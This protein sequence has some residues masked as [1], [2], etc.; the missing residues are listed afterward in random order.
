MPHMPHLTITLA[1]TGVNPMLVYLVLIFVTAAIVSLVFHRLRLAPIPA[2]LVAGAIIGP[3]IL[4]IITSDQEIASISHLAIVLLMFGIG[5]HMDVGEIRGELAPIMGMGS[6]MCALVTIIMTPLVMLLGE[7]LPSSLLV[8][9]AISM[10]STAAVMQLLQQRRELRDRHGRMAFGTLI[11]QDLYVVVVLAAIPVLVAWQEMG[12]DV[13][14]TAVGVGAPGLGGMLSQAAIAVAGIAAIVVFGLFALPR[15][16]YRAGRDGGPELVLI[17]GA[18]AALGSAA[19]TAALG[20]SPELGAFLA[21]FLLASTPAR[22]QLMGQLAPMRDLLLPV[23]FV[24]VG[25]GLDLSV[26][27]EKWWVILIA[28]P[29]VLLLKAT[30]VAFSAWVFGMAGPVSAM[31]GTILAQIGEFTLVVVGA[32]VIG[33]LVSKPTAAIVGVVVGLSLM[34]TPSLFQ[35]APFIARGFVWVR[36]PPWRRK[37]LRDVGGRRRLRKPPAL[38]AIVAG[39]GPVGREITSKL[40]RVGFEVTV[41][42]LNPETV[43]KQRGLG[44]TVVYGDAAN[45]EVLEQSGVEGIDAVLLTMPDHDAM[46]RACRLVRT[47]APDCFLAVRSGFL[48]RGMQAIGVGADHV[49]IDEL[50]TAAM[51]AEEVCERLGDRLAE[52]RKQDAEASELTASELTASEPTDRT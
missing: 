11:V 33:G 46:L 1:A 14:E 28:L 15:I 45:V 3:G 50:A 52:K 40:E 32:G 36:P 35:V 37:T 5:L 16:L 19:A 12:R 18:G 34:V 24:V 10:S 27:V 49:T 20:L 7:P 6:L 47:H 26:A 41:I 25:L 44:R 2:Y 13:G 38:R 9:A 29:V 31:T 23:F 30:I 21:G 22:H 48:S 39:F 42:E 8:A 43:K 4:G 51:M 17:V